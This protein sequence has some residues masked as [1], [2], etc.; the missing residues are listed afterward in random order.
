MF[1]HEFIF[2]RS[3]HVKV[4]L[5]D[6]YD[7]SVCF[8]QEQNF[9]PRE[10]STNIDCITSLHFGIISHK[11]WSSQLQYHQI[12]RWVFRES[13]PLRFPSLSP[14]RAKAQ[15]NSRTRLL[16]KILNNSWGHKV[17]FALFWEYAKATV[18]VEITSSFFLWIRRRWSLLHL[19]LK[20]EKLQVAE[21]FILE[22]CLTR[23]LFL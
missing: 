7:P 19:L 9:L 21:R 1:T 13:K 3:K 10:R 11:G 14:Q 23:S 6:A 8:Q 17:L 2:P 22:G 20:W 5:G 18:V 4:M 16:S 15:L 12:T